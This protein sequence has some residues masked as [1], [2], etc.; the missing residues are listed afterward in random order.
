[1]HKLIYLF[2]SF[3]V[4]PIVLNANSEPFWGATGHRA[5]GAIAQEHLTKKAKKEINKLLQGE[6][7]AFV[8]TFGDDIKSDPKYKKLSPWHYVNFPF[9]TKYEDSDKSKD[10]DIITGINYCITVLKDQNASKED[11]AFYLKFLVHLIGDLHQPMH[12]GKAEDKGGNDLQV[13]WFNKGTNL[14]RIWDSDM[15][16]SFNMSYTELAANEKDLSKQQIKAI[17]N[18]TV[19]DWTYE[20]QLLAKKVYSS[21]EIGEKLGYKYSYDHFETVR[22]QLQKAGIRLAQILNNIYS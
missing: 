3:I 15:I 4:F 7:L 14:H 16:E 11:Q 17:Q 21:A 5:V 1:M 8:S 2:I 19:L 18:G 13:R 10:G 22:T 20:T 6:S 12:V 9:D